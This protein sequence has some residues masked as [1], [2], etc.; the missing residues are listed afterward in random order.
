MADD[1][2]RH[3]TILV[4]EG[5]GDG[6]RFVVAGH[7]ETVGEARRI[8]RDREFVARHLLEKPGG[9]YVLIVS[10]GG[11]QIFLPVSA[12]LRQ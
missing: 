7:A 3:V 1:E 10:G 2:H 6:A 12:L 9:A 11:H 4:G 5:L 8:T